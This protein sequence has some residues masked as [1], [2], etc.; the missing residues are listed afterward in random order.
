MKIFF[1]SFDPLL[2]GSQQWALSLVPKRLGAASQH[3]SE[4][5][6]GQ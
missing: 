6:R 1:V 3:F 5:S 2:R 4:L